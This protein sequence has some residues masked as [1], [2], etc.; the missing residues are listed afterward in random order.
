MEKSASTIPVA[1]VVTSSVHAATFKDWVTEFETAYNQLVDIEDN[2]LELAEDTL[3]KLQRDTAPV[4]RL[5]DGAYARATRT[6]PL[7]REEA[8]REEDEDGDADM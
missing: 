7:V 1:T 6:L 5:I 2:G 3:K 8:L 4:F